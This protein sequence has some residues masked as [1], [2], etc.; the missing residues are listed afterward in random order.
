MPR[1]HDPAASVTRAHR[2]LGPVGTPDPSPTQTPDPSEA[3]RRLIA[4]SQA[5]LAPRIALADAAARDDSFRPV[6]FAMTDLSATF[7]RWERAMENPAEF[8]RIRAD[9][10]KGVQ[11]LDAE[12]RLIE[13]KRHQGGPCSEP[14]PLNVALVQD[15]RLGM[16]R[17]LPHHHYDSDSYPLDLST[18][19][20]D[21]IHP[22]MLAIT[23]PTVAIPTSMRTTAISRPWSVTG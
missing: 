9:I 8:E 16:A 5:D 21:T 11:H 12:R 19:T 1:A 2:C 22:V 23:A 7:D 10:L 14:P 4:E 17:T 18:S 20:C 6:Y 15:R 3:T 13:A